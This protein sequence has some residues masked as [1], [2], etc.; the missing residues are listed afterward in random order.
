MLNYEFGADFF[1]CYKQTDIQHSGVAAGDG[2]G[3]CWGR[4]QRQSA[5]GGKINI[6]SE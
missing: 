6:L 5:E 1:N 2:G 4:P 3:E